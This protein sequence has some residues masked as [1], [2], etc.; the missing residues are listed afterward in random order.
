MKHLQMIATRLRLSSL[1][2]Q[3][4]IHHCRKTL[5]IHDSAPSL[6]RIIHPGREK[7][8]LRWNSIRSLEKPLPPSLPADLNRDVMAGCRPR[9]LSGNKGKLH[10]YEASE[11]QEMLSFLFPLFNVCH[12]ISSI[13]LENRKSKEIHELQNTTSKSSTEH[14][15]DNSGIFEVFNISITIKKCFEE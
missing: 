8:Q 6:P 4:D 13:F 9:E 7:R 14:S 10:L 1:F 3:D 15:T 11:K 5:N 2:I 12:R